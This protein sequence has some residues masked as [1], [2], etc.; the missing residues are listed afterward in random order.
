MICSTIPA[1]SGG[2]CGE[3]RL[4]FKCIW[5]TCCSLSLSSRSPNN[6]SFSLVIQWDMHYCLHT[7]DKMISLIT[8]SNFMSPAIRVVLNLFMS[9]G[10]WDIADERDLQ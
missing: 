4:S 3:P 9:F 1:R 10:S 8:R 6:V 2:E 5:H 7:N